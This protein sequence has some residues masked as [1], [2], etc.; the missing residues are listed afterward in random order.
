MSE[1]E[2]VGS[3]LTFSGAEKP[4]VPSTLYSSGSSSSLAEVLPRRNR[5]ARPKSIS[6]AWGWLPSVS[7]WQTITLLGLMSSWTKPRAWM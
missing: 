6:L 3:P 7:G 1:R 5:R 4:G 2:S